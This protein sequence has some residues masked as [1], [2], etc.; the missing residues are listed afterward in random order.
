VK[1]MQLAFFFSFS[2]GLIWYRLCDYIIPTYLSDEG[3]ERNWVVHYGIQHET[4]ENQSSSVPAKD[5]LVICMYYMMTTLGTVGY[6][7]YVP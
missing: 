5:R 2:A 3:E 1:A 6:G 7:Y 4:V